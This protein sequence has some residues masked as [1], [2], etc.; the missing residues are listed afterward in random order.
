MVSIFLFSHLKPALQVN[1]FFLHRKIVNQG[2]APAPQ[3]STKVI[4][5]PW[6]FQ[7]LNFNKAV[8]TKNGGG[9]PQEGHGLEPLRTKWALG[10]DNSK[11]STVDTIL[12][13]Y[14]PPMLG[15]P[16]Q[17]SP[18]ATGGLQL[19]WWSLLC[20]REEATTLHS[21]RLSHRQLS[22]KKMRLGFSLYSLGS[23]ASR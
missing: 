22:I 3:C 10:G 12:L 20:E 2:N 17:P 11:L 21:V 13:S 15:L 1:I 4:I 5:S 6:S 16:T 14:V 7:N 18:T 23:A 19:M 9:Y 8:R